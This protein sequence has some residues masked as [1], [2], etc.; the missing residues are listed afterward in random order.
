MFARSMDPPW[1][2]LEMLARLAVAAFIGGALGWEREWQRKPAGLRTHMLVSLGAAVFMV[3]AL[4]FAEETN[5][6]QTGPRIDPLRAVAGILGGV[7]FLGAGSI[8]RSRGTVQGITTAA[9]IWLAAAVGTAAGMGYYVVTA[10]AGGLGL[11]I[12][13]VL[14]VLET[15]V[16]GPRGDG[17]HRRAV[18]DTHEASSD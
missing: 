16:L 18:S 2:Y 6:Q 7:G 12:L 15:K 3:I 8:I 17:S 4:D 1:E 13:L 11:V 10:T 14:G 9:S 5:T